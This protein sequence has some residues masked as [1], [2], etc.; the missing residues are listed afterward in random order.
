MKSTRSRINRMNRQRGKN[1]EYMLVEVVRKHG[2]E[3]NRI[4]SSGSSAGFKGDVIF[5]LNGHDFLAECKK[6]SRKSLAIREEWID[7]TTK[8]ANKDNKIPLIVFQFLRKSMW[9]SM[10]FDDF[11]K[12]QEKTPIQNLV[13]V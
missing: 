3:A 8:Y 1:L 9:I 2:G 4:P 5:K 6:T 12:I 11:V 13:G 7:N 10:N